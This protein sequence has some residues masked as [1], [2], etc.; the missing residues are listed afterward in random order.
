VQGRILYKQANISE[1]K[2]IPTI[3]WTTGI[4]LVTI[5]NESNQTTKKIFI[6]N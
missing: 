1:E 6:N 5:Q 2:I 4:Y 3:G